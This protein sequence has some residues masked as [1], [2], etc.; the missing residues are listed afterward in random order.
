MSTL[1]GI[2]F[3]VFVGL[4]VLVKYLEHT[5]VFFPSK[6]MDSTPAQAGM[7]YEDL[8][9]TTSD[10]VKINA[11]LIKSS[12][13]AATILFAHGN[14]GTMSDRVMKIKFFHD[15]GLNVL[16]FDYRGYG[17]SQGYPTE[18]GVYLDAV[19]VY[20]YLQS[21][22]DIDHQRIIGYG[23]S[24]GGVVAVDLATRRKLAAL[25]IESSITSAKDMSQRLYPFLPSFLMSIKFDSMSKI[26][27][28]DVP[29][30]FLHSPEDQIVPLSMGQK[31]YEAAR[32]PKSFLFTY[33]G[34]NDGF[35]INDRRVRNGFK[36]F[37]Q[38]Y[39]LL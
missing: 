29:K 7:P 18:K 31:L 37:L 32:G 35:L 10:G 27:N 5:A 17:K 36:K 12:P 3:I 6:S 11:W 34:H 39:S 19:A 26:K 33:G 13:Q 38:T 16:V 23:A 8:Y 9:L 14:A 30:L 20:D 4:F 2:V 28:I 25:M 24:L 22:P 1:A 21:R 15:L